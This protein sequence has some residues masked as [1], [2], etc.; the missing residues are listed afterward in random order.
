MIEL[1]AC[2]GCGRCYAAGAEK[3]NAIVADVVAELQSALRRYPSMNS[4]AEAI[5]VIWEEF[6][7]FRDEVRA[8]HGQRDPVKMRREL[9]QV[10]AMAVR[11][12][13]DVCDGGKV[14][15]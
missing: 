5:G 14:Q 10:A 6:D 3:V 12:M 11:A 7:E 8:K 9:V 15:R 13:L 1:A 2:H 4:P